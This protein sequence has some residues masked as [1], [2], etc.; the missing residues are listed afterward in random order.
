MDLPPPLPLLKLL[1]LPLLVTPLLLL[2]KGEPGSE[3]MMTGS[4]KPRGQ[5]DLPATI[6]SRSLGDPLVGMRTVAKCVD[7]SASP[8]KT[9]AQLCEVGRRR[10]F[11]F[12]PIVTKF[13]REVQ[14]IAN[15]F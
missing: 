9:V 14:V 13:G 6:R 1:P 4:P 8:S 3:E 15:I 11:V 5:G 12:C 2:L 7:S 10:R